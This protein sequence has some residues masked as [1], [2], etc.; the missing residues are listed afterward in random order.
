M[1]A[2]LIQI[3]NTAEHVFKT[4]QTKRDCIIPVIWPWTR[5][6]QRGQQWHWE[7]VKTTTVDLSSAELSVFVCDGLYCKLLVLKHSTPPHPP[8]C[9]R[10]NTLQTP[11]WLFSPIGF[12]VSQHVTLARWLMGRL[13]DGCFLRLSSHLFQTHTFSHWLYEEE[14]SITK[15]AFQESNGCLER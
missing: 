8:H 13:A 10:W 12:E 9:A 5:F 6:P 3:L 11:M 2:S 7:P 4:A 1:R 14:R 15:L